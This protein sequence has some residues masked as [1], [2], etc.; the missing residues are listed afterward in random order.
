M[1]SKDR[2]SVNGLAGWRDLA[3]AAAEE[4]Q[5]LAGEK[6]GA[7]DFTQEDSVVAG[8][9]GGDY[10]ANDLRERV[11]EK[12]DACFRPTVAN[13]EFG[14]CFWSLLGLG[15]VDGNGLLM[16]L[17]NVDAEQAV[18]LEKG[19]QMATLVDANESEEGIERD[20]RERVGG[21]TVGLAGGL[22]AG[23]T[24]DARRG[25]DRNACGKL[26]E[27]VAK[28]CCRERGGCHVPSF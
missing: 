28:V 17:Q 12:R 6:L 23:L 14:F 21:H 1:L 8:D 22:V 24:R 9:V 3:V 4:K 16:L 15:E 27:R 5:G 20:G 11:F 26:A 7:L 10:S 2:G 25:D 13:A 18:L 19:K